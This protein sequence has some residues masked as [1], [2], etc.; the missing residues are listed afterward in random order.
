MKVNNQLRA[1]KKDKPVYMHKLG[2]DGRK[3]PYH[4]QPGPKHVP[5]FVRGGVHAP[6]YVINSAGVWYMGKRLPIVSLAYMGMRPFE[7]TRVGD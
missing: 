7:Y 1:G 4:P 3:R 6:A 2:K 5:V